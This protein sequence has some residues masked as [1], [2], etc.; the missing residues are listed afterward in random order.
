MT[1]ALLDFN[2]GPEVAGPVLIHHDT[3]HGHLHRIRIQFFLTN[4]QWYALIEC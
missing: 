1:C 4:I 3:D 2:Y